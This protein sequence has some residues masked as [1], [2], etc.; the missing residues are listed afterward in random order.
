MSVALVQADLRVCFGVGV[1]LIDKI[2]NRPSGSWRKE[3]NVGM[4]SR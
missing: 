3:R 1:R 2:P 4:R